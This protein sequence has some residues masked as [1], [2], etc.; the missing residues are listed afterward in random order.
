M[1]PVL[2]YRVTTTGQSP[3][4]TILYICT[5]QVP[6]F[7]VYCTGGTEMPQSHTRHPLSM[8]HQRV[9]QKTLSIRREPMLSCESEKASSFWELNQNTLACIV[10]ALPLSYGQLDN[11]Q[12]S[13]SFVC[14]CTNQMSWVQFLVSGGLFTSLYFA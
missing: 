14:G 6:I 5:A 11:H 13:K 12:P 1:Q 9:A 8:C 4:L 10:S 2:C 3:A 7:Y